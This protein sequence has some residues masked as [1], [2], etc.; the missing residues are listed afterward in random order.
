[1]FGDKADAV[2]KLYP[3]ATG[4][5]AKR[6]A[7]DLAGDQFIGYATWKWLEVHQETGKS[8]VFRYEFDQT[9]PLL[10]GNPGAEPSAPH[11][12]EIEF[13]FQVLSSRRLPWRP[14]D[15]K[16]SDIMGSYWT[17]FAKTGDPNGEG[18]PLWPS[19]SSQTDYQVMHLSAASNAAPDEHRPRYLFLDGLN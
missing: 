17:N 12:S 5:Q 15:R 18:L 11:A 9:L 6:S 4:D 7:Q 1:M 19:Y 14:E 16:L 3:G 10:A 2:L 8:P 13:V